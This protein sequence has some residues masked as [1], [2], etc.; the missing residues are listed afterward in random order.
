[1]SRLQNFSFLLSVMQAPE[2]LLLV[3]FGM[4]AT[5]KSYLASAW[6]QQF[7][8]PYYNSDRVRKELAGIRAETAQQEA[9][10]QGI[11]TPAFSRLTYDT[12]IEKARMHLSEN[13]DSCVVLDGSYQ[14][15]AERDLLREAFQGQCDIV[16]VHCTCSEQLVKER[17][18]LRARDP[19]AVSDGRWEIYVAQKARFQQ[20]AAGERAIEIDTDAPLERLVEKINK[21]LSK[22]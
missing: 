18:A 21:E 6:A 10:N 16:F 1:M 22:M 4:I 5:G 14:A 9:V 2:K 3:F 12:L 17:L 8:V 19:D 11:Y 7:G 20:L 15:R 13:P